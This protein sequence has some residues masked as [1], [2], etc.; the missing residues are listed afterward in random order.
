MKE[1]IVSLD[2]LD[3]LLADF[4]QEKL[5]LSSDKVLISYAER[6]QK[7]PQI[8]ENV[9]YV[10]TFQE[11]DERIRW[12]SRKKI[13]NE[14]T[15][16][17]SITQYSMRTLLFHMVF[18]GPDSFVLATKMNELLYFDSS[19]QFLYKNNLS[20]IPDL[21]DFVEKTYEQINGQ[22]WSRTDL[23]IR[24][25]NSIATVEDTGTIDSLNTKYYYDDVKIING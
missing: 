2:E 11:Q 10:K 3:V 6:G 21:T 18:Y 4:V 19:K 14:E 17:Y 24:F 22:W 9:V 7:F 1:N 23:K 5:N 20:L 8:G 16:A 13:Y 25:Y 15:K 12:K